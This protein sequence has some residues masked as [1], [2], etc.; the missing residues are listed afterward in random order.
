MPAL[1]TSRE[2]REEHDNEWN[3][4]ELGLLLIKSTELGQS[5]IL[6]TVAVDL[7]RLLELYK[8][9]GLHFLTL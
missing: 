6:L 2:G 1:W 8:F 7:C 4:W 5:Y 9:I 3:Q